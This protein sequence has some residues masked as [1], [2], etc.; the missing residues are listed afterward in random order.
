MSETTDVTVDLT[1][2]RVRLEGITRAPWTYG[3]I[4]SI[5]GGTIY[6]SVIKVA[7]VHWD[8]SATE[9]VRP[10]M[11]NYEADRNG[12][13]IGNA[14]TDM[15]AL[16]A[17]VDSLTAQLATAKVDAWDRGYDD[18]IKEHG[19]TD[20]GIWPNPYRTKDAE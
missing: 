14:P 19:G 9:P 7:S 13:F 10:M 16:L 8:N 18:A 15:R 20:Y 4:D 2:I 11:T 6:D 17:H 12:E 5:A 3:D 1:A